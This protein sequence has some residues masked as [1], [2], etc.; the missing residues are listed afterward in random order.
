MTTFNLI[1]D[2]WILVRWI[3]GR[4]T[5]VG[6][7][8]L[9]TS[10]S[11]IADLAVPP[12]ERISILRLLICIT[13]STLGAPETRDDWA[14]WG[15]DLESAT[16]TSLTKWKAHFNLMGDGERFLQSPIKDDK[17]YP[18]A[19]I[20]FHF[21]TGNTPTLLDHEGDEDRKLSPAFLARALL[22]YQNHFVGAVWLRK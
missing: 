15:G 16:A 8:E 7:H 3:D 14:G 18:A 9:F 10:A 2:P 5:S 21:A 12:H 1:S 20:V 19:Q 6:L 4:S 13:Q 22:V 11:Q 17:D